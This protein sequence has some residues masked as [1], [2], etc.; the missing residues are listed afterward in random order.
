MSINTNANDSVNV[1]TIRELEQDEPARALFG[2][3]Y[4]AKLTTDG[5][6]CGC[7]HFA[8][9][10]DEDGTPCDEPLYTFDVLDLHP[11]CQNAWDKA[12]A[13]YYSFL[14]YDEDSYGTV[15]DYAE[16]K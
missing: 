13:S 11:E 1:V 12:K 7:G 3:R 2:M 6:F 8:K 16:T 10:V 9:T 5:F 4:F 14:D 15:T